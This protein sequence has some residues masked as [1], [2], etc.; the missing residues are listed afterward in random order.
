MMADFFQQVANRPRDAEKDKRNALYLAA[1]AVRDLPEDPQALRLAA[2]ASEHATVEE[3]VEATGLP[4][5]I[6]ED[7]IAAW[8]ARLERY[9]QERLA[10]IGAMG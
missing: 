6:V 10:E 8:R 3:I 9:E 1:N 5:T 4:Q 7:Q 2:Y